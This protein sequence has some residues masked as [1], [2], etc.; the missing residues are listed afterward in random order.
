MTK[1]ETQLI[2]ELRGIAKDADEAA[3]TAAKV[4]REAAQKIEEQAIALTSIRELTDR[5]DNVLME[6]SR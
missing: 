6:V 3:P 5:A 4:M 2:A 1:R